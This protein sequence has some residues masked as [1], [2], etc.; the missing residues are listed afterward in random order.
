MLHNYYLYEKDGR[1]SM[2]PWDYN[3]A[4]GG[5]GGGSNASE[6]INTGIDSPLNGSNEA[7]RPMWA[8]I[9]ANESYLEQYHAAFNELLTNYFE[10]GVFE[11][12]IDALY[13]L[14]RPYVE[15]DPSAFYT[16]EEFD[17]AAA[18][19]KQFCLLRAQSIR[20][21][22]S[23]ALAAKTSEQNAADR[24]DAS[25]VDISSMGSHMGGGRGGPGGGQGSFPVGNGQGGFPGGQG[26]FPV[27]GQGGF[28]AGGQGGFPGGPSGGSGG[29]QSG[30]G[31]EQ[32]PTA[33]EPSGEDGQDSGKNL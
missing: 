25:G 16:V 12:E 1:L 29:S 8:W 13:E 24:I 3:L 7:D 6:L 14:L 20:A 30:G 15:K 26:G 22:L 4:Y 10:N 23:G 18:T 19:L 27:G 17:T 2:L 32:T 9:A 31:S 5:F 11:A 28:P 33:P 21:Q